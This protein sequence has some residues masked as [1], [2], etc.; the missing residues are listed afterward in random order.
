M[1]AADSRAPLYPIFLSL[2]GRA[3]L[4]VGG[5]KVAERKTEELL[6]AGARVTV[7]APAVTEALARH[8]EEGALEWARRGFGP[9]DLDGMALA[10]VATSDPD[11]NRRAAS[12]ARARGVWVNVADDPGAC[13]FHV[14]ALLRRG[15]VAVAVSTGGAAPAL[16]SWVRDRVAGALPEGLGDLAEVLA[17]LREIAPAGGGLGA[18]DQRR[19]IGS[20]ILDDLARGDWAAADG[21][22]A[23]H[24]A[25]APPVS[26]I[27]GCPAREAT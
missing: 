1:K 12:E 25:G 22:V 9:A 10:F 14:P 24:F 11:V 20:G 21:K 19:L 15:R 16:A 2:A 3:C 23:R 7:V 6:R 13:D 17:V 4:V 18:E 8:A 27:L 5:G 26:G